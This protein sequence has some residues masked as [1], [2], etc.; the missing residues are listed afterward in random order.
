MMDDPA[1]ARRPAVDRDDRDASRA[2]DRALLAAIVD[3]SDD[4]IVSK[5]LEGVITSWN[6]GAHRIFGYSKEEALGRPI[7]MLI[8]PDRLRE[9]A[10]IIRRIRIGERIDHFE[11]VR[12]TKDGREVPISLTIS[13]VR[14]DSGRIV[15]ASKVARDIT[16]QL[17]AEQALAASEARHRQLI[18]TLPAAVYQCGLDGRIT[19][20]NDAAVEIWGR[21]PEPTTDRWCGSYCMFRP[22]GSGVARDECPAAICLRERRSIRGSEIVIERPDGTRRTVLEHPEPI[23]DEHGAIVGVVNVMNDITERKEAEAAMRETDRRTTAILEGLPQL[24]WTCTPEGSCDFVSKQWTAYT[25]IAAEHQLGAGWLEV[26][27]PD[28]RDRVVTAWE[29]AVASA[30]HEDDPNYQVEF[31]IQGSDGLYQWF[32]VSAEPLRD[33][34]GNI[35]KWVGSNTNIQDIRDAEAALRYSEEKFRNLA[36]NMSQFA[37]MADENWWI[38]WYNRRWFEYTGT[39]IEEMQ[40]WGWKDVHHPDHVDRVVASVKHAWKTGKPWE[41]VFPLRSASGQYRWFLSR[42]EPIRDATGRVVRWFGTNTDITEQREA[43]AALQMAKEEAEAANQAKDRFLAILSH[44]LRTPLTP[45]LMLA[46]AIESD[47]SLPEQVRRDAAMIRD[48]VRLETKLI[49]DLLDLSRI[50]AGKLV[51]QPE[52]VDLNESLLHVCEMCSDQFREKSLKLHCELDEG[53]KQISADSARLHQVFWNVLKNA[54]KFTPDQGEI[55]ISTVSLTDGRYR[56]VIRDTGAGIETGNLKRI[57][58]AFEQGDDFTAQR[59]GGLGLGLAISKALVELHNGTICASSPGVDQGATF[60]IEL[61]ADHGDRTAD[62]AVSPFPA[63]GLD[64]PIRLLLV[65][66]HAGTS[67]TLQRILRS[68]GYRVAAVAT[69]AAA[70]E[71]AAANEFDVVISDIGLPD[72]TGYDLVSELKQSRP[73]RAIAITGYGMAE[74][75]RR[76]LEAGFAEHLIKPLDISQL[77]VAIRRVANAG[78]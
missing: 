19:I 41:D 75:I 67:G 3:S 1:Q 18:D 69:K 9:E 29:K 71:Y 27:H 25:G 64:R 65:E 48:N 73:I 61:P 13:A 32:S 51:L 60:T 24:I 15:G 21:V 16:K 23:L 55:F 63:A 10:E 43:E 39:S 56:V 28:D 62:P 5:T 6:R 30:N 53:V 66:D 57:F 78:Q 7:T 17:Q 44:E 12:L 52:I 20:F 72:G 40:G 22:D 70:L 46:S 58:E 74:D 45:V 33:L 14:D 26:V 4:A 35:I 11:T 31:R 49:D 38:Y 8:P 54:A 34:S 47:S 68:H 77:D 59:F 50:T 2:P 76:S 37:W 36:D 42:A